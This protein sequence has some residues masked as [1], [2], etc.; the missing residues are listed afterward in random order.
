[1]LELLVIEGYS[2]W[3]IGARWHPDAADVVYLF[4]V[5]SPTASEDHPRADYVTESRRIV[6]AICAQVPTSVPLVVGGD[7]NFKS[8]GER[9]SSE[10]ITI[11]QSEAAA[12]GEFRRCGFSVA[13]RDCHRGD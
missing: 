13:W 10:S 11:N 8:F 2:G 5:H 7:F 9:L 1:M 3:V 4:S 6:A 12:L